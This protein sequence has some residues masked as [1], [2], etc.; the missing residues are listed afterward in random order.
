MVQVSYPGVYIEEVPSGVRAISPVA[1]SI[2]AFID[3][4][5]EGPVDEAVV[6]NGMADFAR[7]FGGLDSRS[8]ASYGLMQFFLNGGSRAIVVR[9]VNRDAGAGTVAAAADITVKDDDGG[10]DVMTVNA[11][12]D[13]GWGNN[14]RFA[15]EHSP[16]TGQ[17]FHLRVTR[18]DS[19]ADDASPVATEQYLNLSVNPTSGKYFPRVVNGESQLVVVTHDAFAPATDP[20]TYVRPAANGSQG[21]PVDA[22]V[23]FVQ[24]DT[25]GPGPF[26]IRMAVRV[27]TGAATFDTVI[28]EH[29]ATLDF[30]V[31]APT[32]MR[33]LRAEL[34]KAIRDSHPTATPSDP[35][36][37]A[38]AGASVDL[39]EG[40]GATPFQFVIRTNSSRD[41]YDPLEY[42]HV[43]QV[44]A[45]LAQLG[46]N[47][48]GRFNVQEYKLAVDDG[49]DHRAQADGGTLGNDGLTPDPTV[50]QESA[51][52]AAA[53]ATAILGDPV[54]K[55][56]LHALEDADLFNIL[57]IPLAAK[58]PQDQMTPV[59]S[60]ALT[61]CGQERAFMIIDI[62]A[63]INEIQ[64]TSDW[65]D[66][67][68]SFRDK[69]SALYFPR[70]L[71]PDPENDFLPRSVGAS[72]TLAGIY[73]RTD[74]TRGVW[75]APAG[76]D[77]KLLGITRLDYAMTDAENGQLNPIAVN[78]LRL[79][80]IHGQVAWGARTLD[81]ADVAASEWKY[82]PVRRLALMLE[83]SLFR[84]THWVVFEP[85]DEPTW[86]K[87]RQNVGA[88]MLNLFRQG[89][90]QGSTPDEA[91]FVKCDGETTTAI[92]RNLGIV[93]IEVG[94]APLKPAEFVVIKIQQIPDVA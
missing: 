41:G 50:D 14:L 77:A 30:G 80:P 31:S 28:A 61:F 64:E 62:P 91:F 32:T 8:E 79:F 3:F 47:D 26:D 34:Q 44:G 27:R 90:F 89:A 55:E 87:V 68:A 81:G 39:I 85:N 9:V 43:V 53:F 2:A 56:G 51:S 54:D 83:E 71:M 60:A 5:R 52:N 37:A 69:S 40:G 36:N 65:I 15:I 92:D 48:T 46:L 59:I 6:I 67:N 74:S 38:F 23:N 94:F 35:T 22:I 57:C 88:F 13:G 70:L 1:T 66:D 73:S 12:S 45:H 76:L 75:K 93:N 72:G 17:S 11:A 42:V 82:I 86:A 63:N 24:L 84:G 20:A 58:L 7:V 18:Y 16:D 21:Q 29:T 49:F 25:G 4:F 33:Q 19:D 78:C 10:S